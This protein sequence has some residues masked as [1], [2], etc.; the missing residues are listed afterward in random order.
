MCRALNTDTHLLVRAGL[1]CGRRRLP[2]LLLRLE[3]EAI[4]VAVDRL[5]DEFSR[6]VELIKGS[7]GRVIAP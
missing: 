3:Q 1:T 5:G 2:S 7:S 4:G 6:A